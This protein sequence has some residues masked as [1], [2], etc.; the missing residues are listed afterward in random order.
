MK[1]TPKFFQFF[2]YN[3]LVE[4]L[5]AITCAKN[6]YFQAGVVSKI[7]AI[8]NALRPNNQFLRNA[9]EKSYLL[10]HLTIAIA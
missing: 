8:E 6:F 3:N 4:L 9:P 7:F 5:A 1:T 2:Y 10:H